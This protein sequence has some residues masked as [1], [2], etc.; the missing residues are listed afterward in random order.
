M[1][2]GRATIRR[3]R[4]LAILPLA[5]GALPLGADTIGVPGDIRTIQGAID[6]AVNGDVILVAPGEYETE[7]P[8]EFRGKSVSVRAVEGAETTTLRMAAEPPA[9]DFASVV[10][11]DQEEG[12]ETLLEGFTLTG[13]QG[14]RNVS[15]G[16]EEKSGG[17]IYVGPRASPRIVGCTITENSAARGGGIFVEDASPT[18]VDCTISNNIA[19][20]FGGGFAGR[21]SSTTISRC[22]ISGEPRWAERLFQS[23]WRHLVWS[24]LCRDDRRV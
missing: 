4:V 21:Q 12:P 22:V 18:L 13:G 9:P 23:G 14:V 8:I 10:I 3:W 5:A 20:Q 19:A 17:A 11:F 15:E 24:Q 16:T 7:I 6:A 2:S 1:F